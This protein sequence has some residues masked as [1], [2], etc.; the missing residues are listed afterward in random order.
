MD[1][2]IVVCVDRDNDLGKKTGIKGPVIGRKANLEAAA[3]LALA[4]P[5]E[6]DANCI[7]AAVKKFDLLQK[8]VK[9]LQVVTLTGHG[10]KGFES[11]RILNQQLDMIMKKFKPHGF[12]L[13]TDG[14]E[15]DQIIPILQSRAKIVSK[16]TVIIKQAQQIESAFFTLK[17]VIK[18][19]YVA[20]IVFGIPAILLL[21]FVAVGMMS[22]QIIA[23][24]FGVYLLLKGFGLEEP[25]IDQF[26]SITDSISVQRISFPFYLASLF[27]IAFGVI[28]AYNNFLTTQIT[29]PLLDAPRIAQTTYPFFVLAALSV[30][31]G[32]C[33]D[34]VHSKKAFLLRKYFLTG[35][36]ILL[37]WWIL[38]TATLVFLREVDLNLFLGS[39]LGSFLVLLISFRLSEVLNVRERVTK[40]LVGLPIYTV[41]GT[42]RGSVE[43]INKR[44]KSITYVDSKTNKSVEVGKKNFA[45]KGGKIVLSA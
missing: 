18:D 11:D 37:L 28:T 23:F 34:V 43:A 17:E 41:N 33:V 21:L 22:F 7:F 44:R 26:R 39:V 14:A 16:E 35:V 3:K 10:K 27:I 13:V 40:L 6:S 5:T 9:T 25:I 30:V 4:D 8:T 38:D 15:D 20:R 29:E 36:S 45:L 1:N 19:P 32:R 31:I 24:V 42:W 2:L 12:V